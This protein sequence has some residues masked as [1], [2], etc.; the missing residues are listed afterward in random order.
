MAGSKN[1]HDDSEHECASWKV[2]VWCSVMKNKATSPFFYEESMVTGDIF[3]AMTD[4]TTLCHVPM[5]TIF[6]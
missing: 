2:N 4:T 6:W 1:P 5:G 3:L